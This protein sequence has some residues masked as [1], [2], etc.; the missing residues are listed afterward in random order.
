MNRVRLAKAVMHRFASA[1]VPP[2]ER[3]GVLSEVFRHDLFVNG[4]EAARRRIMRASAQAKYEDEHDYP[5]DHY[6]G[7]NLAPLLRGAN[8]LDLGC[9]TGGRSAAWYER[10][11]L[12][13][14]SG[15]DVA[16]IYVDAARRYAAERGINADFRL[17][18]G[19]SLP[20]ANGTFDAVLSFDVFEHV[21]DVRTTLAECARVLR[22]GGRLF[23]VF[24]SYYQPIE[25][26]L[27]LVTWAPFIHLLFD[28]PTLMR[29]YCQILDDRGPAA[30]WYRRASPDLE[31]WERLNTINGMTLARFSGLVRDGGWRVVLHSRRP[32]GSVGRNLARRLPVRLAARAVAPL[33]A[34]PGIQEVFLHRITYI[35]ERPR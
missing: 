27:T 15:V 30:D 29:A 34:I 3:V 24:P 26:H 2:T 8:V 31:P 28:P 16:P 35:L 22:P 5:W 10:Y 9:F 4:D 18:V 14:L 6:F 13:H 25:H 17:G 12:A 21:R 23:V 33:T 7:V 32:I 1:P 19:E 20:F 11:G